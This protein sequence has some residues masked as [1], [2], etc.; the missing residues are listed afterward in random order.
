MVYLG[1]LIGSLLEPISW[2]ILLICAVLVKNK[3]QNYQYIGCFVINLFNLTNS[4]SGVAEGRIGHHF[5]SY[6]Y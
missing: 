1:Y 2:I 3:A 6:A 5:Y 4:T